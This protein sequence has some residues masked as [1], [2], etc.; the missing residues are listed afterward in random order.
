[1]QK[2][3]LALIIVFGCVARGAQ[4]QP[5]Y[6]DVSVAYQGKAQKIRFV[7]QHALEDYG[8]G[9]EGGALKNGEFVKKSCMDKVESI[10]MSDTANWQESYTEYDFSDKDRQ[11]L[12]A[13][14]A[15]ILIQDGNALKMKCVVATQQEQKADA[16]KK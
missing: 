7:I 15:Y 8:F 9:F 2:K 6:S 16:G 10:T 11:A 14:G 13:A 12:K 1:M 3:L 5:K 4:Q